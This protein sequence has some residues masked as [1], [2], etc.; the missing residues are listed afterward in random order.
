MSTEWRE[1][2]GIRPAELSDFKPLEPLPF[3]W[4]D[5][6]P[7]RAWLKTR[8]RG[9]VTY[10]L[11]RWLVPGLAPTP[12]EEAECSRIRDEMLALVDGMLGNRSDASQPSDLPRS[13]H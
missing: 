13:V 9:L 10:W 3:L 8:H 7:P 2:S 11:R 5:V 4:S 12:S 6:F 1:E